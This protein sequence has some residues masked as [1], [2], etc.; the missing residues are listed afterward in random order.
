[1]KK[2][3]FLL[4]LF[5]SVLFAQTNMVIFYGQGCPHCAALESWLNEYQPQHPELNITN[6]EIYHNQQNRELMKKFTS[7]YNTKIEGVP[8]VFINDK[9]FVG[10]S[11]EIQQQL[12]D[13]INYCQSNQCINPFDK[14]KQDNSSIVSSI[15]SL[16]IPLVISA[17]IVDAI[18]PCAFAVLIILL[19]TIC[20]ASNRKKALYSGLAFASAVYISYFLMGLGLFKVIQISSF[21]HLIYKLIG[22]FAILIGLVNLKDYF[23]YGAGGFV[24]EV[25]RSWRPAMKKVINNVTSI[26]GSF[27]IGFIISLFLLPCTSGPYIVILGMLANQST[28]AKAIPLL[29]LYNLIFI[30]PMILISL[31]VYFGL[32]TA[33]QAEKIRKSRIKLLHLIAGII[34]M[35]IGIIVIITG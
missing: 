17:A 12:I 3:L 16:T 18:N 29:L 28:M 5:S 20:S 13:E 32:S 30:L 6:Y 21:T 9:I 10:Y 26:K 19:S 25:P 27:L 11:S 22:G 1:M 4:I 7:S 24:I 8:T 35:L 14:I 34:M 2:I 15:S 23:A 31:L 33:E